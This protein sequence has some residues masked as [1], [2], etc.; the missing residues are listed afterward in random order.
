MTRRKPKTYSHC[1]QCGKPKSAVP[2]T[3]YV[4]R[5]EYERD[6]YCSTT[7]CRLDHGIASVAAPT[8]S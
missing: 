7:C 2:T 1:I 8:S 3:N 4:S 6:P 5:L